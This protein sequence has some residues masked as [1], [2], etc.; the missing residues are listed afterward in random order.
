VFHLNSHIILTK[1][2]AVSTPC[3]SL[4]TGYQSIVNF[5]FGRGVLDNLTAGTTFTA[6][7]GST[8]GVGDDS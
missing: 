7:V 8:A 2:G 5:F 6:G 4:V 1:K 3:D